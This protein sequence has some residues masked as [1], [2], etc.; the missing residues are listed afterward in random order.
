MADNDPIQLIAMQDSLILAEPEN[1]ELLV[2]LSQAHVNIALKAMANADVAGAME[3]FNSSLKLN[4]SNK[5][6]NYHLALQSGHKNFIKGS[7]MAL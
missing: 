6:A 2:G 4:K 1:G 3:S 7:R 5:I